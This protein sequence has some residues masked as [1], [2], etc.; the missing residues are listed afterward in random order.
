MKG[1]L[2]STVAFSL[3]V[4][5]VFAGMLF[6]E[7]NDDRGEPALPVG[8]GTVVIDVYAQD[9]TG[10]AGIQSSFK[11]FDSLGRNVSDL[12]QISRNESLAEY[13]AW[14]YQIIDLGPTIPNSVFPI[15]SPQRDT[16]GFICMSGTLDFTSKTLLYSITYDYD[17]SIPG[18]YTIEVDNEKT[19]I[20]D[21]S[22]KILP[23]DVIGGSITFVP[24][25]STISFVGFGF[26]L[27]LNRKRK[28]EKK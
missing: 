22:A 4:S 14:D 10:V 20:S 6:F 11:F 12:F 13:S 2:L 7:G 18:T 19:I 16:A 27:L 3:C 5:P 28:K 24:E 21:A 15:W 26:Y 1:I 8:S 23:F 25:P 17:I 9:I